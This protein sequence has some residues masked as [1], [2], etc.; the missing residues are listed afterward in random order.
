MSSDQV[1]CIFKNLSVY[2][3]GSRILARNLNFYFKTNDFIGLQQLDSK[4][5]TY[6]ITRSQSEAIWIRSNLADIL[7]TQHRS[8]WFSYEPVFNLYSNNS[9]IR[10]SASNAVT[11]SGW[12]VIC[13][14]GTMVSYDTFQSHYDDPH[15]FRLE[16]Q[17]IQ[18]RCQ[19]MI[20]L[21]NK[22]SRIR[23][24]ISFNSVQSDI[25]IKLVNDERDERVSVILMLTNPP[26]MFDQDSNG[27]CSRYTDEQYHHF[28]LFIL[29]IE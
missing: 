5:D 23:M 14:F 27:H 22:S 16:I 25:L 4:N 13:N 28:F 2:P 1:L 20:S 3:D 12:T 6:E 8:I 24:N 10:T 18:R 17:Y 9:S 15:S 29:H 19:S 21:I 26:N 11:D 7:T